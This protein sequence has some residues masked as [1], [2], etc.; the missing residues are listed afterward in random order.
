MEQSLGVI[1]QFT[2]SK[3]W[4]LKQKMKALSFAAHD[5]PYSISKIRNL[6]ISK[7]PSRKIVFAECLCL[8]DHE[9]LLD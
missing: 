6:Q 2:T 4:P 8:K 1:N 5:H 7:Y 3:Y 9:G